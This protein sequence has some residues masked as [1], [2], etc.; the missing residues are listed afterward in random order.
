MVDI[1]KSELDKRRG[2]T[3]EISIQTD[4]LEFITTFLKQTT[5]I[6]NKAVSLWVKQCQSWKKRYPVVLA[7]YYQQKKYVNPYVF[8]KYLSEELKYNDVIIPDDGGH[9]TWTMQAFEIKQGQRLFSAFGNSPMGYAFPAAIGASLALNRRR[10]I[11]I[12]G[13]GSFQI[14]IQELQTVVYH[15]LP[16][17]IFILNN[18]GY[19][20]IKQFQELYL[21]SRYI[22]TGKGYSCP[23]FNSIS[24]SYGI[25]AVTIQD[26]KN[27]RA[28]IREVLEIKGPVLC[29]VQI[30]SNQKL[31]PKLTFGKPIED[32]SPFLPRKEFYENMLIN[33]FDQ[34]VSG[35]IKKINEIN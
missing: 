24:K 11:C 2:L 26:H 25:K 31:I 27:L 9:L 7:K 18:N 6:N 4:A 20:I 17:K 15:K 34:R 14:N 28:K 19:G 5:T 12:D 23:D 10:V 21:G 3:P 33:P 32:L 35:D 29:N 13:D 22:A 30:K 8:I 16:I 1:D